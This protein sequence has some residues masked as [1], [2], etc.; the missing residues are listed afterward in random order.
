MK[1]YG[2]ILFHTTSEAFEAERAVADANLD[3]RLI[4]TP[5]ELSSDCGIS[6]QFPWESE[7]AVRCV[8]EDNS[9]DFDFIRQL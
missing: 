7:D 5:R 6:L 2:V 9:V 1:G 8:L 3:Y 4:P